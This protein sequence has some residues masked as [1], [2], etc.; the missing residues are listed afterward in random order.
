MCPFLA[1]AQ[2][3]V[4]TLIRPREVGEATQKGREGS[5]AKGIDFPPGFGTD[6]VRT[7]G[8]NR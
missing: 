2:W 4:N 3:G 8:I 1:P 7:E 5:T 6:F